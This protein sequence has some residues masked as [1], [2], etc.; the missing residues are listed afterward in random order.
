MIAKAVKGRGFRGAIA[1]DLGKDAGRI[2]DTNMPGE[3]VPE[4]SAEFGAIRK[5]RPNLERAVLHVSLS[6]APGEKL[7]DAQWSDIS[8]RYL[9]GMEFLDNQYLVTRYTDTEHEHIHILA[10]RITSRGGVVSDS[11][12]YQR[13]EALMRAIELEYGLQQLAPTIKSPRRAP[14]IGEIENQVRTGEVSTRVHST[15]ATCRRRRQGLFRLH[16]VPRPLGRRRRPARAHPAT[17]RQPLCCVAEEIV[18]GDR[19]HDVPLG[20]VVQ[21]VAALLSTTLGEENAEAGG[22]PTAA[23]LRPSMLAETLTFTPS[24]IIHP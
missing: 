21:D 24:R 19:C 14:T 8:R 17:R 9:A 10:N 5:L 4:L 23:S 6:A 18:H 22:R 20:D 2:L 16:A 3:S 15:P 13:Q 11:L 1:Y 12:D 7:T